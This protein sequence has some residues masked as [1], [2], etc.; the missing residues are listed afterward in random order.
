MTDPTTPVD[1]IDGHPQLEAIAAAVWEHCRTEGTSL[2]VDDPRNIAVAALAA[3]L[4]A[5]VDR[6]T[7]LRE[8]ADVL[9]TLPANAS[10]FD[11]AEHKYKGRA[12][13]ETLRRMAD[14]AQQPKETRP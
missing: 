3:V 2:V 7:L 8:A 5:P 12:A 6:A 9:D 11:E 1:W 14:E 13:A 10:S 4:S